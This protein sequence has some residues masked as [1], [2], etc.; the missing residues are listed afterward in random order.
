MRVGTDDHKTLWT[1]QPKA[2]WDQIE[3]HGVARVD[4]SLIAGAE[5]EEIWQYDWLAAQLARRIPGYGGGYPWWAYCNK[6]DLRQFRHGRH[7]EQVCVGFRPASGTWIRYPY[8]MWDTIYQGRYLAL[9]YEEFVDWTQAIL[10]AVPDE[11]TWPLPEPW[12]SRL[13]RSWERLFQPGC[14]ND[15][16]LRN[17]DKNDPKL[18]LYWPGGVE[19]GIFDAFGEFLRA[20]EIADVR[21]F[22]GKPGR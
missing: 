7:G 9:S 16:W 5:D 17:C 21:H 18:D 12:Q 4:R 8:W 14:H 20:S 15:C 13:E 22:L 1:I 2:V 11:D 10:V 19:D 6:P 3:Q